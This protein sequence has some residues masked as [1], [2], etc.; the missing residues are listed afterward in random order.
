MALEYGR[1]SLIFI[2]YRGVL[3]IFKYDGL[4]CIDFCLSA[5]HWIIIHISESIIGL[6]LKCGYKVTWVKVKGHTGSA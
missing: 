6:S 1:L 2:Y 3:M 5:C 4:I